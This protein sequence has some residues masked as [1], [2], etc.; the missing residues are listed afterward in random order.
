VLNL[1]HSSPIHFLRSPAPFILTSARC[2]FVASATS[3]V[4]CCDCIRIGRQRSRRWRKR[5]SHVL[6]SPSALPTTIPLPSPPALPSLHP[7]L[8]PPPPPLRPLLRTLD[9]H[10]PQTRRLDL[11][12]QPPI[13]ILGPALPQRLLPLV[14]LRHHI[15]PRR[16]FPPDILLLLRRARLIGMRRQ[17]HLQQGRDRRI[18]PRRAHH[19]AARGTRE[20]RGVRGRGVGRGAARGQ[21]E[22]EPFFETTAA[23][24]VQAVEEGEGL[25]EDVGA[26]LVWESSLATAGIKHRTKAITARK[27]KLSAHDERLWSRSSQRSVAVDV[28]A[29][30]GPA[31]AWRKKNGGECTRAS[32]TEQVNSLSR[33]SPWFDESM[34]S[35]SP[36]ECRYGED[37]KSSAEIEL[38]LESWEPAH[39]ITLPAA[40]ARLEHVVVA[41]VVSRYGKP[42][43]SDDG[44]I[45]GSTE[46]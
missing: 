22:G 35:L 9:A 23:E 18:V 12:K 33:S 39:D 3:P 25:V 8:L 13:L 32:L 4:S 14:Y 28:E 19:G 36:A 10:L 29:A 31:L 43:C 37:N 44:P 11:T 26:D 38:V 6:S 17:E 5:R 30:Q 46:T 16:V 34:M 2:F 20:G 40:A 15:L 42:P 1:S 24:G 21:L 41:I 45:I 27:L 7:P